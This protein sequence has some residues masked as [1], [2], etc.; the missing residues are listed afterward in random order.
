MQTEISP[1]AATEASLS[2]YLAELDSR[3]QRSEMV[4]AINLKKG[5]A[6]LFFEPTEG[7]FTLVEKM[8]DVEQAN[9]F[10]CVPR[11]QWGR[12]VMLFGH[13]TPNGGYHPRGHATLEGNCLKIKLAS[14]KYYRIEVDG[15]LPQLQPFVSDP[16]KA[17]TEPP[18][19]QRQ[20]RQPSARAPRNQVPQLPQARQLGRPTTARMEE[21]EQVNSHSSANDECEDLT[22]EDLRRLRGEMPLSTKPKKRWR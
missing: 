16:A 10:D 21:T 7:K 5:S 13:A 6:E 4:G 17:R 18:R 8:P 11:E 2:P 20:Q 12:M 9:V 19:Q 14:G 3:V 22:E 15:S 1:P